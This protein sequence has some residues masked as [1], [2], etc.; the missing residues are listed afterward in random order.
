MSKQIHI[1]MRRVLH[2]GNHSFGND[3]N[4]DWRLRLYIAERQT[5]IVFVDDIG[6]GF[7]AEEPTEKWFFSLGDCALARV[8]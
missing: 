8:G 1:V 6:G 5:Y 3:E 2:S 7:T 4:M